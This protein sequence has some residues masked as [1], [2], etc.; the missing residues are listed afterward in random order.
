M[1]SFPPEQMCKISFS[2]LRS[3]RRRADHERNNSETIQRPRPI[4]TI[5]HSTMAQHSKRASIYVSDASIILAQRTPIVSPTS[6]SDS[7][8]SPSS[9]SPDTIDHYTILEITPQASTE[10]IRAAYRRLRVVY[11]SSDAK[12]Y[13]ALQ[14]AFD[15]LMDPEARQVYDANYQARAAAPCALSSIG[16]IIE[17]A[18][19]GRKDSAHGDDHVI[20]EEEEEVE[21]LRTGDPN[22][23]L[24]RHRRTHEPL[25]GSEP[26]QSWVPLP[27]W[28]LP[29]GRQPTYVGHLARN[30]VPN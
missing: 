17:Q 18:K 28:F 23:G 19:H 2:P 16:E 1:P 25:L 24:K 22:W 4:S 3:P 12:K 13:R 20:P 9:D 29:K 21:P 15:V 14:A 30:A 26:Y 8:L 7:L 6:P 11:F 5:G 10:D 27:T